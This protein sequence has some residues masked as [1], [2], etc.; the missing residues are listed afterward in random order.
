MHTAYIRYKIGKGLNKDYVHALKSIGLARECEPPENPGALEKRVAL[1]PENVGALINAGAVVFVEHG[2]GE[3]VGFP[4]E[5]Y[6]QQGAKLQSEANIYS[7]KAAVLMLT[8][9]AAQELGPFNIR[10][11]TV[12]PGLIS[13]SGIREDWPDGVSRWES[14]APLGRMG[15]AGRLST[16][17]SISLAVADVR[18]HTGFKH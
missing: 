9:S 1:T 11:N 16:P 2:A 3:R 15:E 6:L 5:E 13:R 17:G 18:Y 12:S 14:T 4:D 8:R 7:A 10:V